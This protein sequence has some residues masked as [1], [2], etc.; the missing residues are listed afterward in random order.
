LTGPNSASGHVSLLFTIE[1]QVRA[2]SGTSCCNET[3][4][5]VSYILKLLKPIIDGK[6]KS[7][8]VTQK[9]TTCYNTWIRKRMKSTIFFDCFS[10]YRG[11]SREGARNVATFPGMMTLFWW[12]TRKPC[13]DDFKVVG[14]E[15]WLCQ[16]R[17]VE[18]IVK[19]ALIATPVILT[20][21]SI[22]GYN[23]S[24]LGI[25]IVELKKRV[26]SGW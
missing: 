23:F 5:Q 10:Y 15:R 7:L 1:T 22:I 9:A 14:G 4:A 25:L 20:A 19:F 16:R 13:W 2:L 18:L 24:S 17:K 6:A 11:D 26:L 8:E 3:F 12:I 21:V